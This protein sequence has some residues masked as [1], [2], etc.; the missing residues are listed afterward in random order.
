MG[1]TRALFADHFFA[2]RGEMTAPGPPEAIASPGIVIQ[3]APMLNA[4]LN[5]LMAG[6]ND[7]SA[8]AA[9]ANA[10]DE[11]LA[12]AAL[13]VRV[14]RSNWDYAQ[15]EIDSIDALLSRRYGLSPGQAREIRHQAEHLEA[16]AHD[17][18]RFTRDIKDAVALETRVEIIEALWELILADGVRDAEEDALMRMIGPLLGINDRDSALA[19]QRVQARLAQDET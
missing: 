10:S 11:R 2:S 6:Q 12:L 4:L 8:N 7:S 16:E 9:G 19:R 17:T 13:L 14:A 18:V 5:R 3:S 1:G 15:E